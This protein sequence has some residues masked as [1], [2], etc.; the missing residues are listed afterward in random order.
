MA[1]SIVAMEAPTSSP[2]PD[3]LFTFPGIDDDR[4]MF[5]ADHHGVVEGTTHRDHLSSNQELVLV[6]FLLTSATLSLLG[7]ITIMTKVIRKSTQ[8]STYDRLMMCLSCSN[9]LVSVISAASPFLIPRGMSTHILAVGNDMTCSALGFFQQLSFTSTMY[10]AM[11]SYYYLVK[12][13]FSL[14]AFQICA[15]EWWMHLVAIGIPLFTAGLGAALG[16]Y[17]IMDVGVGC[18]TNHKLHSHIWGCVFGLIP[19]GFTVVSLSMN[20]QT[21]YRH[22]R[23]SSSSNSSVREMQDGGGIRPHCVNEY[24]DG[25][26]QDSSQRQDRVVSGDDMDK[27]S[28]Q[29]VATQGFCYMGIYFL[30]YAS[31]ISLLILEA[32]SDPH[33]QD[34][35][36]LLVIQSICL[37]LQG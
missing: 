34:V 5:G 37:P 10:S 32:V 9:I 3:P 31:T 1:E 21:I 26:D 12:V 28:I 30:S 17:G 19:I 15:W 16:R 22:I 36:W 14:N 18:W 23:R 25:R 6:I 11:L 4:P 20:H 35:Y 8:T 13:R 27:E 29:Q 2:T 24:F 7:S 33:N